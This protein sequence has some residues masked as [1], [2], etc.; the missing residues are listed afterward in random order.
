MNA[1]ATPV[2]FS[3]TLNAT[4]EFLVITTTRASSG[5]VYV[6][7]T[8]FPTAR[9]ARSYCREEARWESCIRVQC[10]ALEIDE[11]GSFA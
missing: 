4:G 5:R 6:T 9:A 7:E 1:A 11:R 3:A 10:P 2:T 8:G